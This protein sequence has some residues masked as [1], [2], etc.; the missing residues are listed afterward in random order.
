LC[1]HPTQNHETDE[2][3]DGNAFVAVAGF[4]RDPT[5]IC[6]VEADIAATSRYNGHSI[7]I[8]DNTTALIDEATGQPLNLDPLLMVPFIGPGQN[9]VAMS[10]LPSSA[11]TPTLL[12]TIL[13][14][15]SSLF[16]F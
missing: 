15:A 1:A 12:V 9:A 10:S 16:A 4:C 6:C 3:N 2:Y 14:A 8:V 11:S 13:L 5:Q 7:N